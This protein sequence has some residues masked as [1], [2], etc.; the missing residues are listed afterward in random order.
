[1]ATGK[2]M[3][4]GIIKCCGKVY[5]KIVIDLKKCYINAYNTEKITSNTSL[6]TD[7]FK[8]YDGLVNFGYKQHYRVNHNR[9]EF[10]RGSSHIN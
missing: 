6:F 8:S 5:T 7:R 3:V 4:F 10:A 2:T 9:N 1:M